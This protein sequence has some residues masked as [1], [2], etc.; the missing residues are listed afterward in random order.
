MK[1]NDNLWLSVDDLYAETDH[2]MNLL[3]AALKYFSSQ[4]DMNDWTTYFDLVEFHDEYVSILVVTQEKV[5]K[6][7]K[8]IDDIMESMRIDKNN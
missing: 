4:P 8:M 5:E 3:N 1:N 2:I 7:K 6:L